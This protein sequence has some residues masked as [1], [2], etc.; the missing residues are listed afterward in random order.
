MNG[1]KESTPSSLKPFL[2]KKNWSCSMQNR[3]NQLVLSL[4]QTVRHN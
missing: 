2:N 4:T 3:E 1:E